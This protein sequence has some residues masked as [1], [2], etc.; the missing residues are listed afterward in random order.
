VTPQFLLDYTTRSCGPLLPL[1]K[2]NLAE[3]FAT[4]QAEDEEGTPAPA[5]PAPIV[6]K[7]SDRIGYVHTTEQTYLL[8]SFYE[9]S[10]EEMV[11]SF[12]G[13]VTF[14]IRWEEA[15]YPPGR[16]S[17]QIDMDLAAIVLDSKYNVLD[18]IAGAGVPIPPKPPRAPPAPPAAKAR[19]GGEGE[20]GEG[21]EGD[22]EEEETAPE[23]EPEE[24]EE[25][26][27]SAP[28]VSSNGS[29]LHGGEIPAERVEDADDHFIQIKLKG[30]E[31]HP[32]ATYLAL[33]SSSLSGK[34][35]QE[36]HLV[37]LSAHLFDSASQQELLSYEITDTSEFSKDTFFTSS[38]TSTGSGVLLAVLFLF[39]GKWYAMS[40]LRPLT[41][42]PP[43]PTL[44]SVTDTITAY[45][46][47]TKP[48]SLQLR[49]N[50]H[51]STQVKRY[52]HL[53]R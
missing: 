38:E 49:L 7:P 41:G 19:G 10:A 33:Y 31:E 39:E 34:S 27:I 26:A 8:E 21:E 15:H 47:E 43:A 45:L 52:G 29:L 12:S 44:A 40:S 32:D 4:P 30:V 37:G 17:S 18:R 20:D 51:N 6:L 46:N 13:E 11:S 24:E 53:T 28:P 22:E 1:L 14:G 16:V 50:T 5:P 36:N 9:V 2:A 35:F 25:E 48:L 3:L 23:P 42:C